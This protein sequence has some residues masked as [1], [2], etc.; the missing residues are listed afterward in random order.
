MRTKIARWGNSLAL[1]I[2][3]RL[4]D[5]HHLS[6]GSDLEIF[7]AEGEIRIR[8]IRPERYRLADLLEDVTPENL[9]GEHWVDD[10]RGKEIW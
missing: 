5:A 10:A 4:A 8:P 3:K 6:E 9:H 1:R 2:P 7:E